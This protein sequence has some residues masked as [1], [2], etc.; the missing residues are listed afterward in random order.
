MRDSSSEADLGPATR[1]CNYILETT[2]VH[3]GSHLAQV[4][5]QRNDLPDAAKRYNHSA[6][7]F[8]TMSMLWCYKQST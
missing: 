3:G 5:G 8:R 6:G 1:N 2:G 7:L 4:L